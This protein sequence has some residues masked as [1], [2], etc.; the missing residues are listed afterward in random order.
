MGVAT[1]REIQLKSP[2]GSGYSSEWSIKLDGGLVYQVIELDTNLLVKDTI[3][4]VTIDI[5]GTPVAYASGA[6]LE[7]KEKA[8][9]KHESVGRLVMDLAKFEYR[10]PLG[11]LIGALAL[12]SEE[13]A[14][15]KI[16]F[17]VKDATDPATPT[18]RGKAWV[19][20]NQA[21]AEPAGGRKYLPIMK[22]LTKTSPEAGDMEWAYQGSPNRKL[23]RMY[24]DESNVTVSKVFVKRGRTTIGEMT[25]GDIDYAL[26]RYAGVALPAGHMLIDFTLM[27]FGSED[28]MDTDGLNFVFQTDGQGAMKIHL[29]GFER[30]AV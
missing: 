10:S 14:T 17:G 25:R 19:S 22:T 8:Y 27:G 2:T 7:M 28:A 3:A 30:V 26:Q 4:K 23:Q 20:D 24:V 12:G 6:V 1:A 11:I 15:L 21:A 13:D 29:D 9:Q 5:G 18:L 16:E